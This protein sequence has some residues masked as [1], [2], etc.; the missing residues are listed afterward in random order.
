MVG[1]HFLTL[2]SNTFTN[3]NLARDREAFR[4]LQNINN[5]SRMKNSCI[6]KMEIKTAI[7][8]SGLLLLL[9]VL[10]YLPAIRGGFIWD[11]DCYLTANP[12]IT[13][14]DGLWR[15]WFSTHLQSQYQSQY[16][17]LVYTTLRF[18]HML[19]GMNPLGY[20]LVNV[21]LHG[22]NALML[23]AILRRLEVTGAFL[24]AAI[25][26]L[27][28]VH[29]ETVAWITEL[30]NTQSTMFYLLAIWGWLR[31]IDETTRYR[32]GHYVFVLLFYALALFSKTT[33]CTLPA[34]L[35]L[36][37]WI[38]GERIGIQRLVQVLPFLVMG[39]AMGLV[40]IWW[41]GHMG[42]YIEEVG[43]SLNLIERLLIASRALWFYA[44]KLIW[45]VNL[46]F[47][48][49][50]W[51]IDPNNSFQ[52]GWLVACLLTACALWRWR[53]ILGRGALS[54][55]IFFVAS[56]SPL[57][58]FIPLYTFQ[59]S[60]VADHYQYVASMGLIALFAAACSFGMAKWHVSR[61]I[62]WSMS[63]LL[64]VVLG[65]LTWRQA[66][67]YKNEETLW[68]D[69]VVKNPASSMAHINLACIL[70]S[71]ERYTDEAVYHYKQGIYLGISESKSNEKIGKAFADL[72]FVYMKQGHY[73]E[74]IT[75]FNQALLLIPE[76]PQIQIALAN[77]H[78]QQGLLLA[79]RGDRSGGVQQWR[80]ALRVQ[81]YNRNILYQLA[82]TLAT[83]KDERVRNG[84]EAV[85]LAERLAGM[86][87]NQTPEVLDTLGAAY[88]EG[89]QMKKAIE[90]AE[91]ALEM[92]KA[93][94]NEK[95]IK[96]IGRHLEYYKAGKP[97]HE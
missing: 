95:M 55:I 73:K 71:Q 50:K 21:L 42:H 96:K 88:A 69:T 8:A 74:A 84:I 31:F 25:F 12:L 85:G 52:Y 27:H 39:L 30:K 94:N 28:P 86:T 4:M 34:A 57:L 92:A 67:V 53:K 97:Y 43:Q 38:R 79:G 48:Y 46:T 81:P 13:A 5:I 76:T 65:V 47:S 58:G 72:G 16:F 61:Y 60:Y 54:G 2:F 63:V 78:Y 6:R 83:D 37:S 10:V 33:A 51:E 62:T 18:E 93:S 23:F 68:R 77:S 14:P 56:L 15:I 90:A 17:P 3:L 24:A 41:E 1:N 80:E 19:W 36:A 26:A 45:P 49:P 82:Q 59:Y 44:S 40:S 32:W 22:I 29:V 89:G 87:T 11:D 70:L 64:L 20:H 35:L 66:G 9:T 75:A 7:V 91:K